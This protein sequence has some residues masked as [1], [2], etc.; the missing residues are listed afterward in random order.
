MLNVYKHIEK[1]LLY[2]HMQ[3]LLAGRRRFFQSA[4][5]QIII[6]SLCVYNLIIRTYSGTVAMGLEGTVISRC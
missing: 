4:S 2:I 1:E 5:G 6:I 3:Q